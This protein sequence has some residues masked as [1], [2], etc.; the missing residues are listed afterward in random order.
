MNIVQKVK[1]RGIT[2]GHNNYQEVTIDAGGNGPIINFDGVHTRTGGLPGL[3][4]IKQ[5][6]HEGFDPQ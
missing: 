3:S 1:S 6:G 5:V 2:P 4:P